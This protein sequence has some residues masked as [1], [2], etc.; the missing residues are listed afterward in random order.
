MG[1]EKGGVVKKE[2]N[3]EG[4]VSTHGFVPVRMLTL[5]EFNS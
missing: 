3:K 2:E 5:F 1:T 4:D